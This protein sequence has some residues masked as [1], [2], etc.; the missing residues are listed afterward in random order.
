MGP[1]EQWR[2]DGEEGEKISQ[3]MAEARGVLVSCQLGEEDEKR[4]EGGVDPLSKEEKDRGKEEEGDK[5]ESRRDDDDD[6][7]EEAARQ[8]QRILDELDVEDTDPRPID[9][10][11]RSPHHELDSLPSTP[12]HPAHAHATTTSTNK[13]TTTLTLPSVPL[14][15]PS[16]PKTHPQPSKNKDPTSTW[17]TICLAD[18]TVRCPG[19]GDDLYCWG[20]WNE[21]HVGEGAG[22]EETGHRWVGVGEGGGGGRKGGGGGR[23]GGKG[24]G[25][26]RG[27]S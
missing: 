19:C 16:P 10:G 11:S 3:L 12:I 7:E 26:G 27:Q 4:R 22:W 14:T 21:G 24:E 2:I 25:V 17:C 23:K 5:G 1:E 9:E 18:A 15:H 20:C 13:T 8:L 6:D